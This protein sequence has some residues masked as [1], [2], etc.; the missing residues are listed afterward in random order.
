MEKD[1]DRWN[2]LKKQTHFG[3]SRFYTVREIWWCRL[4]A[5]V[6]TEQ[7]GSG[8]LFLRPVVIL[9]AFGPETCLVVPLTT[10]QHTHPLRIPVGLIQEKKA[11]AVLSQ[12]RVIDTRRLIE[13]V[14]FLEKNV[15][16]EL[17]KAVKKLF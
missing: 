1:F 16:T 6:G 17:R 4:G 2:I 11:S 7:D 5:N 9:R 10:S 14:G 12:I 13:K 15:F 3:R 8:R